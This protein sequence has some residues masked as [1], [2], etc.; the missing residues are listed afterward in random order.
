MKMKDQV[1]GLTGVQVQ[2]LHD[3]LTDDDRVRFEQL[4]DDSK[5]HADDWYEY[6]GFLNR[7]LIS[8]PNDRFY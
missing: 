3:I 7:L 5:A 8:S 1:A 4:V 6:R 2:H